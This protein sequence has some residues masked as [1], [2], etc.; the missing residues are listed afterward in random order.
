MPTDASDQI[1]HKTFDAEKDLWRRL[2]TNRTEL[3]KTDV[4][5]IQGVGEQL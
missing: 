1:F 5:I 2:A 3:D 4:A